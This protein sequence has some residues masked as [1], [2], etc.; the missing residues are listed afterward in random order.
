MVNGLTQSTDLTFH[1]DMDLS[2]KYQ[3]LNTV[4]SAFAL[5]YRCI[6]HY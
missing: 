2:H 5:V 1:S 3:M 6:I 4:E